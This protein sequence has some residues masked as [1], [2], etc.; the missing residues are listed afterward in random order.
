MN[1]NQFVKQLVEIAIK[2][3]E[4]RFNKLKAS[5]LDI[6]SENSESLTALHE[7]MGLKLQPNIFIKAIKFLLDKGVLFSSTNNEGQTP[8]HFLHRFATPDMIQA[9][10][11]NKE[12]W[13]VLRDIQSDFD[14]TDI[15]KK[16][17][18]HYL[19]AR[20]SSDVLNKIIKK[21]FRF[22]DIESD[23]G[24]GNTPLHYAASSGDFS[25]VS[26]FIQEKLSTRRGLSRKK[27]HAGKTPADLSRESGFFEVAAELYKKEFSYTTF[28]DYLTEYFKQKQK[29][30][31]SPQRVREYRKKI[32]AEINRLSRV[33]KI[34]FS[35]LDEEIISI[36]DKLRIQY[37]E[38]YD[39]FELPFFNSSLIKKTQFTLEDF[40]EMER[41]GLTMDDYVSRPALDEIR[42]LYNLT[43]IGRIEELLRSK[44]VDEFRSY[45]EG[46][47]ESSLLREKEKEH[48]KIY[49]RVWEDYREKVRDYDEGNFEGYDW[50]YDGPVKPSKP[51]IGSFDREQAREEIQEEFS[52]DV[53]SDIGK[54]L[55][56]LPAEKGVI[57]Q[58]LYD[59]FTDMDIIKV[60]ISEIDFVRLGLDPRVAVTILENIDYQFPDIDVTKPGFLLNIFRYNLRRYLN[61]VFFDFEI[62]N[63]VYAVITEV[64]NDEALVTL[65]RDFNESK[66]ELESQRIWIKLQGIVD[67][68]F[69]KEKE[70]DKNRQGVLSKKLKAEKEAAKK[71]G[72]LESVVKVFPTDQ[73]DRLLFSARK[74]PYFIREI[75]MPL[76]P[77]FKTLHSIAKATHEFITSHAK[78]KKKA[79]KTNVVTGM[80]SFV[81]SVPFADKSTYQSFVNIPLTLDYP[82]LLLSHDTEDKVFKDV[83]EF[84]RS[85]AE[86]EQ[87]GGDIV[88]TIPSIDVPS[89]SEEAKKL[90]LR[91]LESFG[92][93]EEERKGFEEKLLNADVSKPLM[94]EY[95]TKK[96]VQKSTEYFH[97]ERIIL[98]ALKQLG[99]VLKILA[100]L[101]EALKNLLKDS[102]PPTE[103]FSICSVALILYSHPNSVC[104]KCSKGIIAAQHSYEKG[105]LKIL[106]EQIKTENSR[107]QLLSSK[108]FLLKLQVVVGSTKIFDN[109]PSAKFVES[110]P[111]AKLALPPSKTS[112]DI[113]GIPLKTTGKPAGFFYEFVESAIS[114]SDTH[115][116]F[117]GIISMSGSKKGKL[118]SVNSEKVL[119]KTIKDHNEAATIPLN[120]LPIKPSHQAKFAAK[121]G[122]FKPKATNP[123]LL[124][125]LE[126]WLLMKT[127]EQSKKDSHEQLKKQLKLESRNF[128]FKCH[129]VEEDGNCFF[130]AVLEQLHRVNHPKHH[131]SNAAIKEQSVQFIIDHIEDFCDFFGEEPNG[132]IDKIAEPG[133]W[134]DHPIILACAY[135]LNINIAII[136]SDGADPTI[137]RLPQATHTIYLGYE[138]GLHYQSLE[139]D[140]TIVPTKNIKQ[141]F[142]DAEVNTLLE[143]IVSFEMMRTAERLI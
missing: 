118:S 98:H 5:D 139:R 124:E 89:K 93:P 113:A 125:A 83:D 77:I 10:W 119:Q 120:L 57:G 138:V 34:P 58:I 97:S 123:K 3:D 126:N 111:D 122:H 99:N 15:Y 68:I 54:L 70:K 1:E 86:D 38:T 81:I 56:A 92:M 74:E 45:I 135:I 28:Y 42:K 87:K 67:T 69:T 41:K 59:A 50:D 65:L 133:E 112:Y 76:R 55:K 115:V 101:E 128:G 80:L 64:A 109:D 48:D 21:Y 107:F 60:I 63:L 6:N 51:R 117:S 137:I 110:N 142:T 53:L 75:E 62:E 95:L 73:S 91:L 143:E 104:E 23:D 33:I 49:D 66:N 44:I 134:A 132:F 78:D 100:I 17:S 19:M 52:E 96:D 31:S 71:M 35:E 61:S 116:P 7:L 94:L 2:Q 136:R 37:K 47:G 36:L 114:T 106:I 90:M 29:D 103:K 30:V 85:V 127:I 14:I 32:L 46:D 26:L 25:R 84:E 108:D 12:I 16:M 72:E 131:F 121:F 4:V 43:S 82:T 8:F 11:E 140:E 88:G 9:F 129:N 40:L 39:S 27:N 141:F 18:V 22:R 79:E 24:E 20:E 102:P 130:H 105:F 13:D